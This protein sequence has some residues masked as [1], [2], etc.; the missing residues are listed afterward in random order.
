MTRLALAAFF[1][2]IPLCAA[3]AP[4]DTAK[5][6]VLYREGKFEE[7][8]QVYYAVA[9]A[10]PGN[11]YA[12]YNLGNTY[13]KASRLGRAIASYQRAYRLLPRDADIRYNLALALKLSGQTLTPA[14]VPDALYR[15]YYSLS[16]AE[17][18]GLFWLFVWLLSAAGLAAAFAKEPRPAARK[19]LAVSAMLAALFGGWALARA[20]SG[21]S[22]PGVVVDGTAELRGGPGDNFNASATVPEGR[23][24]DIIQTGGDWREISV[25]AENIKGWVRKPSVEP[26]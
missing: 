1:A 2:A 14:G 11:P 8:G 21:Y 12:H 20:A 16:S 19:T 24:V 6:A 3:A 5:A 15:A 22:S 25:R 17:L 18:A 23:M 9:A 10:Q 7:A 13:F 26:L 4:P